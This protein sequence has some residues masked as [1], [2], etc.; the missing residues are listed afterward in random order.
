MTALAQRPRAIEPRLLNQA[1]AA[2]YCGMGVELLK[3]EFPVIPIKIRSKILYDRVALDKWIDGRAEGGME[4][5][6]KS[7]LS[8]LDDADAHKGN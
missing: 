5:R 7:W 6:P 4:S 2:A 1:D 8:R 3:A